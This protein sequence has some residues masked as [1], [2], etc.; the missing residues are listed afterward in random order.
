VI[1]GPFG[2]S[3]RATVR[4]E[5]VRGRIWSFEQVQG[6]LYVHVPVRMTAV[7]LDT[8]GLLLYSAI[9]PTAECLSLLAEVE[10]KAGPVQH[11]LLP[12]LAV[13]HKTYAADFGRARPAATVWV[14]PDQYTF[15]LPLPLSLQGF[16]RGVRALPVRPTEA[17]LADIPWARQLSYRVLGP[18]KEDVGAFEELVALDTATRT[19][20]ARCTSTSTVASCAPMVMASRGWPEAAGAPLRITG[21]PPTADRCI[22]RRMPLRM[23]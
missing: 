19:L 1:Q 13:E 7:R 16:P 5:L 2:R 12:S 3:T 9:A 4:R 6:L 10:E 8:G 20:P 11:I 23:G 22:H 17:E 15:P 18:I 21:M 14:V